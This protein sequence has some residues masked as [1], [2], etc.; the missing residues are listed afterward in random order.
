MLDRFEMT[1]RAMLKLSAA[2]VVGGSVSG[3]FGTLAS[4]VAEAEKKGGKEGGVIDAEFE[5]TQG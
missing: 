4:Q 1:R 5:E 3:W 2:G